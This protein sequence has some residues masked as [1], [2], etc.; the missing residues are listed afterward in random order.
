MALE[1]RR[2]LDKTGWRLL[3]EL[4]QNARLSYTELGQRVGLSLPA[5]TDR[6]RRMEEAGILTGYH[7]EIDLERVGLPVLAIVQLESIGGRSCDYVA[8]QVNKIPE[9]LECYRVIGEDSVVVHVVATSIDH[10]T[11]IIDQLSQYGVPTT[12]I[13][14]SD[15]MKRHTVSREIVEDTDREKGGSR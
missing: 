12:S 15:P 6:I 4:Q 10:L 8:E 1:I 14:R 7:A 2:L 5:V 9:V 13:V 3:N 11:R